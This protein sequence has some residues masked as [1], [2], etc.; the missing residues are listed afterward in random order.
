MPVFFAYQTNSNYQSFTVSSLLIL[1]R[2]I[3]GYATWEDAALRLPSGNNPSAMETP[4]K[5][6]LLVA[7]FFQWSWLRC[8]LSFLLMLQA[9]IKCR[10]IGART[11]LPW[12]SDTRLSKYFC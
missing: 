4:R 7:V 3:H 1:N 11:G 9:A 6:E 5:K 8:T 12:Q 2:T 10:A